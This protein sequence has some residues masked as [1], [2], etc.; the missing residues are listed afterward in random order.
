M[1]RLDQ[2]LMSDLG[3]IN[4]N[5]S[6]ANL[7]E[8]FSQQA[9]QTGYVADEFG[10]YDE[11]DEFGAF[12]SDRSNEEE[13]DV[14]QTDL[15]WL[16]K[17]ERKRRKGLEAKLKQLQ[18]VRL[19]KKHENEK[20]CKKLSGSLT[21]S[22]GHL[23]AGLHRRF[24]GDG[25]EDDDLANAQTKITKNR[26]NYQSVNYHQ[27]NCPN[28]FR[29]SS[30]YQTNSMSYPNHPNH[31]NHDLNH[32]NDY[33]SNNLKFKEIDKLIK[34]IKQEQVL[35]DLS[36]QMAKNSLNEDC[37][38]S[39]NGRRGQT[40]FKNNNQNLFAANLDNPSIN[41]SINHSTNQSINSLDCVNGQPAHNELSNHLSPVMGDLCENNLKKQIVQ[42]MKSNF[43]S[44]IE[45]IE[46]Q[47][48]VT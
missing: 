33:S 20:L 9:A 15:S 32:L 29:S 28:N 13:Q 25:S 11:N 48:G 8:K 14:K 16:L 5:Y 42:S 47:V 36:G 44:M 17:L 37:S 7:L 35:N 22:G 1:N 41:Q 21:G 3:S 10:A 31:S 34:I 30:S 45:F 23:R 27:N 24:E 38:S 40:K 12:L 43:N 6:P 2:N 46:N 4:S 18:T 39:S 19:K 26:L